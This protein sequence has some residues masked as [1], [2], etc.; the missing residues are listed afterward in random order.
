MSQSTPVSRNAMICPSPWMPWSYSGVVVP[1]GPDCSD[2]YESSLPYAADAIARRTNNLRI[3]SRN[4]G[5][6]AFIFG[7]RVFTAEAQRS[8]RMLHL[9]VLC[10]S[11]VKTLVNELAAIADV[12]GEDVF[13]EAVGG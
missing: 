3:G 7:R 9:R 8:Q 13:A 10:A 5:S 12:V 6:R 4:L 2:V 11:A 1:L